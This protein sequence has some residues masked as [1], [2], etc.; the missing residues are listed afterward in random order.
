M[1][2]PEPVAETGLA[3]YSRAAQQSSSTV[4]DQYST[5]FGVAS[6]LLA[7]S[8][9]ADVRNIYALVRIADEIVDG[10]AREAGL[11]SAAQLH[12]LD[13]LEAETDQA[14]ADGYSTNLVVHAFAMTARSSGITPELTAPFFASMRRDLSPVDFTA[15]ELRS[16]IHGSAEVVGLMCLRV[17]LRGQAV[18]AEERARLEAGACRLGAAFQKINFLR[19][20][21]TDWNGLQRNYFPGVD[22]GSLTAQQKR[23]LVEDVEADLRAAA[24]VIPELPSACRVAVTAAHDL[25]AA[26]TARVRRTPAD[27]LLHTRVRVATPAK[28]GVLSHALITRSPRSVA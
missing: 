2:T 1:T 15:D 18:A 26:L 14:V 23:V 27:E 4:I 10:A 24:A 12:I 9:R 8:V 13:A 19:D 5:S 21:S 28:L 16:Y 17:F 7:K 3:L 22:P 20:F 11:D 6:R 25:F